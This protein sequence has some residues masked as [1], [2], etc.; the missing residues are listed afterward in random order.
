[1]GAAGDAV[2]NTVTNAVTNGVNNNFGS[3]TGQLGQFAS[4]NFQQFSNNPNQFVQTLPSTASQQF[5]SQLGEAHC[6]WKW[7]TFCELNTL[8]NNRPI[9][10]FINNG[11][12]FVSSGQQF[13][14]TGQQLVQSQYPN[15]FS[16]FQVTIIY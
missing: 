16:N 10:Q 2:T 9:G 12:Q 3:N 7:M 1:M 8:G 13:V 6:K 15:Q 5:A 11:Q 14:Q 4:Q